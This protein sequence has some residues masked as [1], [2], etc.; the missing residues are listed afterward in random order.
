MAY[1]HKSKPS[2][3]KMSKT[4]RRIGDIAKEARKKK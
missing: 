1:N 2:A 3:A 4:K